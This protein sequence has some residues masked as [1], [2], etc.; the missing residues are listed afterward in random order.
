MWNRLGYGHGA[1]EIVFIEEH[2]WHRFDGFDGFI[3]Y[4][5][6]PCST[7]IL[8]LTDDPCIYVYAK[9]LPL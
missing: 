1:D 2:G 9:W 7:I 3:F 6:Q 8:L 4:P 5:F